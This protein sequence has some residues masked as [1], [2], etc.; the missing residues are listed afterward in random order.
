MKENKLV[1]LFIVGAP[2]AGTTFLYEKLKKHQELFFPK[3]KELNFFSF[4]ELKEIKNY[5]KDYK[6]A[7]EH[8]YQK[9]FNTLNNEKYAVD[10]SVSYFAFS[11]IPQKIY[12]YNPDAKIII[13]LRNPILRTFSHFL[14]DQRMGH[15]KLQLRE[16]ILNKNKY[17]T[18]YHQ[19]INNSLY[20]KNVSEFI[21]VF[22]K[23][24][25]CILTLDNIENEFDKLYTFLQIEISPYSTD[26]KKVNINKQVRFSFMNFFLKNRNITESLK[27]FIPEILIKALNKKLYTTAKTPEMSKS[28][29]ELI[30]NLLFDDIKGLSNFLGKDFNQLWKI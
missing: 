19:Y 22:G 7:K 6:I 14:M 28:D 11:T 27:I 16:Y 25:V 13:I 8:K 30:K 23:E 4:K 10:S 29:Y 18:H 24:N 1:N 15:A 26:F 9:Q 5:Y 20:Y 17:S 21:S 12:K 3:I 2:K